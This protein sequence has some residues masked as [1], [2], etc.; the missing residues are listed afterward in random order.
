ML[1]TS[2]KVSVLMPVYNGARFIRQALDS[3]FAQTFGDFELIICDNCSTDE[4]VDII[5]EYSSDERLKLYINSNNIGMVRNW[6][7]CILKSSGEYLQ[8]LFADDYFDPMYLETYVEA[9]NLNPLISIA[10]A[11]RQR[12]HPNGYIEN[13]QPYFIGKRKGSD[14]CDDIIKNHLNPIGEPSLVMFRKKDLDIGLFNTDLYWLADIDFWLRLCL[15][16]DILGLDKPYTTFRISEHQQT[17]VL[18]NSGKTVGEER[19]FIYYNIYIR[20]NTIVNNFKTY[21]LLLKKIAFVK[22][23]KSSRYSSLLTFPTLQ[24]KMIIYFEFV[25]R[26]FIRKFK[27]VI[28]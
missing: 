10:F 12:L 9:L 8:F 5:N 16:G 7:S 14:V 13:L 15:I 24:H 4:T 11:P 20:P 19:D 21:Q 22:L 27:N 17:S 26:D 3:V 6:N 25:I 1:K 2:P 23:S 18:I 28:R